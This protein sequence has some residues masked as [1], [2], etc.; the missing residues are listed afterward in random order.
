MNLTTDDSPVMQKTRELCECLL[1]EPDFLAIRERIATFVA[2]DEAR[3]QY[4]QVNE[5]GYKL[6]EKQHSGEP[7]SPEEIAEFEQHREK[8]LANDV[9]RGFLE[10][11]EEMQK[12]K[13]HI[14]KFITRTFELG[15]VP[16]GEDMQSCGSGCSCH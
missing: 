14:S 12:A 6:H 4:D 10:A 2:D 15:R 8:L 5:L 11:Q 13:S 16:A 1:A 9:A 7:L 3:T